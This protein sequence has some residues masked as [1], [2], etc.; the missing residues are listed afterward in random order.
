MAKVFSLARMTTATV[1]TGTITLGAA[2]AGF[3]TFAQAGVV[4]GDIV[5]YGIKDGANSEVGIGTY[6]AGTLTRTPTKSTSSDAA[7]SLSGAAE[8]YITLRAE[9]IATAAE[10]LANAAAK[11]LTTDKVWASAA[12]ITLTD[13]ASVTPDFGV[14]I[15]FIWTLGAAGRTLNNPVNMKA[16]QKGII[17]L[18]QDATGSRTIT[19]WGSFWKFAGGTKPT[20]STAATAVDVLSYAYNGTYLYCSFL[21]DVK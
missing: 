19:T 3:L 6:S 11:I 8:V 12:P 5:S 10:W 21:A 13:T 14:G 4:N 2:V 15:D 17:Y 9:D 20:L 16:G 7:I 18:V 1:G